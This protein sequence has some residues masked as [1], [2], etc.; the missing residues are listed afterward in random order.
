[1]LDRLRA[2]YRKRPVAA[3]GATAAVVGVAV[4]VAV[5]V[6]VNETGDEPANIPLSC[7]VSDSDGSTVLSIRGKVTQ[8]EADE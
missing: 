7:S 1:M 3:W 4:A 2:Q 6:T 5:I 8:Q